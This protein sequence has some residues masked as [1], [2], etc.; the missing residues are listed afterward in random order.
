MNFSLPEN[1]SVQ[2]GTNLII[3]VMYGTKFFVTKKVRV[4]DY[5]TGVPPHAVG[6]AGFDT[7]F[8]D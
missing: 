7:I 5:R 4:E 6:K 8:R 1:S 2:P 3:I